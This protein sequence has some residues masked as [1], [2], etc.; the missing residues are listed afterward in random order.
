M[1]LWQT[2]MFLRGAFLAVMFTVIV[3]SHI[4]LGAEWQEIKQGESRL[5]ID[6]PGLDEGF[7]RFYRRKEGRWTHGIDR[8]MDP[9]TRPVP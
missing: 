1:N 6:T 8:G 3:S 5:A 4:A 9:A 7:G 2:S